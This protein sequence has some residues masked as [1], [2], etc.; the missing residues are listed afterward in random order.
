[1]N[2][3]ATK[4]IVLVTKNCTEFCKPWLIFYDW[5]MLWIW[6]CQ[7]KL[8]QPLCKTIDCKFPSKGWFRLRNPTCL[9]KVLLSS[10]FFQ[11]FLYTKRRWNAAAV[12]NIKAKKSQYWSAHQRVRTWATCLH[13]GRTSTE[14]IDVMQR[15]V[16]ASAKPVQNR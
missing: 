16:T 11:H 15:D 9:V 12:R 1:M 13:T 14:L 7:K 4:C 6:L 10:F 3:I 5:T 8:F 2:S